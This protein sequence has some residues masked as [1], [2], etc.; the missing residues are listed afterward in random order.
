MPYTPEHIAQVCYE[1]NR[2][3]Q[4]I[5][6]DPAPS[7][8]WG[9]AEEWQRESATA[10]ARVALGG[11]QDPEQQHKAWCEHKAA[12]GWTCGP[13][14]DAAAKTHPCLVPY[15]DLPEHEKRKDALFL[16][17]VGALG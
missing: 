2:A 1:A 17:I 9:E 3:F 16:A 15:A 7:P 14:K 6:H 13:V 4:H 5:T 11:G 8:P 10:G 12:D